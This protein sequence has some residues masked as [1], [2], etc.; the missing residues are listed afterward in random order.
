[1]AAL[2]AFKVPDAAYRVKALDVMSLAAS[3]ESI[4]RRRLL[5]VDDHALVRHGLL[6]LLQVADADLDAL[7]A[8]CLQDAM[9]IY[10]TQ[11]PID[12]VLL[13]LNMTDCRGL[14]GL[15]RFKEEFP[16]SRIVVLSATQDEFVIRQAQAL[17]AEAYIAKSRDPTAISQIVG[18]LLNDGSRRDGAADAG[19]AGFAPNVRSPSYER[20]AELGARHLEIMD[21]VLFGCSNQEISNATGLSLGTIK[22]YVSVILLALDVKS[23]AHLISLFR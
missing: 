16:Q 8:A 2:T 11:Q 17:G 22:N 18:A 3:A 23:R 14:Q 12:L 15:R 4:A 21:L 6:S 20:V 1:M 5:V 7:Q 10:R 13:D 9:D 19:A